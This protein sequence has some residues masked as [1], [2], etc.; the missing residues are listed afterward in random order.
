MPGKDERIMQ[1]HLHFTVM[2][3]PVRKQP[4]KL[5][6]RKKAVFAAIPV[7]LLLL[8]T[9]AILWLVGYESPVADPYDS[10]V[11]R[12][13]LFQLQ[14]DK[15]TTSPARRRFFHEQTFARSKPSNTNR[16]FAFGGS[17]TYGYVLADPQRDSY[18]SQ[19]GRMLE[20]E[21]PEDG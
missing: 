3:K 14:G 19:L 6:F 18:L 17:T 20:K 15:L 12:R 5:T 2:E 13:P 9:E 11:L 16:I 4:L 21:F 10:F 7:A 8:S 1:S